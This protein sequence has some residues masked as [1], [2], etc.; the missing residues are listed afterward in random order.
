M[1]QFVIHRGIVIAVI[2]CFFSAVFYFSAVP[3]FTGIIAVGYGTVYTSAPVFALVLDRDVTSSVALFYPELYHNLQCGLSLNMRTFLIWLLKSYYQG[4]II[5]ISSM[6]LFDTS[7]HHII[8]ISFTALIAVELCNVL[9]E[10]KHWHWLMVIAE[11]FSFALYVAS[12]FVLGENLF[13][14]FGESYFGMCA[15]L[16]VMCV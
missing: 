8:S 6:L 4:G 16:C 10:I 3:I 9:M 13:G 2:Q 11:I 7:F 1:S 15:V 12:I 14:W 5:M